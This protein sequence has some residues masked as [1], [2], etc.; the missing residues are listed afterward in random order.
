MQEQLE[1]LRGLLDELHA[2]RRAQKDKEQSERWTRYTSI[3]IVI[4]AV[5]TAIA[6]LWVGKYATRTLAALNDSTFFQVRASDNWSLY[7]AKS[8]KQ[9]LYEVTRD[10]TQALHPAGESAEAKLVVSINGKVAQYERE[11]RE[12]KAQSEG[13]EKERDQARA[14]ATSAANKGGNMQLVVALLQIAVALS[15]IALVAKN[16]RLWE[17][18]ILLASGASLFMGYTFL[19]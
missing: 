6:T 14:V 15:S 19:Q 16:R 12:I 5:L 10:Q 8:I 9:H 17:L 4:I 7:Q 18:G 11:R 3:S 1:A 13:L 2:E